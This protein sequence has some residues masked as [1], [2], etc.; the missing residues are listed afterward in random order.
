MPVLTGPLMSLDARKTLDKLLTYYNRLNQDIVRKR[1]TPFNPRTSDQ[2]VV[3]NTWSAL[4]NRFKQLS[5]D[6]RTGWNDLAKTIPPNVGISMYMKEIMGM[7]FFSPIPG[8]ISD[9]SIGKSGAPNAAHSVNI[10]MLN[11]DG[12]EARELGDFSIYAGETIASMVWIEDVAIAAGHITGTVALGG[13][14]DIRYV[15]LRK[16]YLLPPPPPSPLYWRTGAVK[17]TLV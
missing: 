14:G 16:P 6:F 15:G 11:L 17:F 1:V 2:M 5:A 12:E 8:D 13:V 10:D 7:L 4:V 9:H 3:R